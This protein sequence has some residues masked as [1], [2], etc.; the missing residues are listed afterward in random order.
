MAVPDALPWCYHKDVNGPSVSSRAESDA[1]FLY[2]TEPAMGDIQ[3]LGGVKLKNLIG[4]SE[5]CNAALACLSPHTA[6]ESDVSYDADTDEAE[7]MLIHAKQQPADLPATVHV[8]S[9]SSHSCD[10]DVEIT[11]S[12]LQ[13]QARS[14]AGTDHGTHTP[15]STELSS[16]MTATGILWRLII[17]CKLNSVAQTTQYYVLQ[18]IPNRTS[19]LRP[20]LS[21]TVTSLDTDCPT[22]SADTVSS[23]SATAV[24]TLTNQVLNI[25]LFEKCDFSPSSVAALQEADPKL[26][27]FVEYLKDG[28]LPTSQQQACKLLLEASDYLLVDNRLFCSRVAKSKRAKDLRH[29]QLVLPE[30]MYK[31]VLRMYHDSPLAG[32]GGIAVTFDKI[33]EHYHFPRMHQLITDYVCSCHHCQTRKVTQVHTKAGIVA[34]RTPSAPFQVWQVDLYGPLPAST[35]GST[36]ILTC[37]DMF[38]KY[39]FATPLANKDTLT[40]ATGLFQLFS[41]FDICNTLVSNH[42]SEFITQVTI[43]EGVW[44]DGSHAAV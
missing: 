16:G 35:Q 7:T 5:G 27:H 2:V 32:H 25:D 3:H 29:Y 21:L 11:C 4:S 17:L 28:T 44:A 26:L 41:T 8:A 6:A 37:V 18:V 12:T 20:P 10:P 39:L 36:Y 34:Y 33:K 38:S 30:V 15:A 40:V 22:H 19:D 14:D 23:P 1:F 43:K 42:G 9:T 31:E 13:R 24:D